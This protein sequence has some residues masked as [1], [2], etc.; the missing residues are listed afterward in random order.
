MLPGSWHSHLWAEIFP[1][2]WGQPGLC[3]PSL[4]LWNTGS[5]AYAT[6]ITSSHSSHVHKCSWQLVLLRKELKP[7]VGKAATAQ[8]APGEAFLQHC[9]PF[10]LLRKAHSQGLWWQRGQ[11][12]KHRKL[13][14]SAGRLKHP[15]TVGRRPNPLPIAEVGQTMKAR[16]LLRCQGRALWQTVTQISLGYKIPWLKTKM[17]YSISRKISKIFTYRHLYAS[18]II[19]TN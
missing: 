1:S 12:A 14:R 18:N 4:R 5:Q 16:K 13:S 11:P 9:S 8:P 6:T 2:W 15:H 3:S 10:Y 7:E 17:F 19:Y